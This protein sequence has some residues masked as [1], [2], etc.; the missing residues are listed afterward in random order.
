MTRHTIKHELA[1]I[2]VFIAI[3][4]ITFVGDWLTGWQ[5]QYYGLQ[6]RTLRGLIGIAM[7][8]LLHGSF[9]HLLGNSISLII[10]LPLLAG[11]RAS[12]LKT[13]LI[14]VLL[15]GSLLWIF[16]TPALHI[17]ASGLIYGLI[18]FLL[19]AGYF[20]RRIMSA[21]IALVVLFFYGTTLVFGVLP[22]INPGISWDGHLMG[23]IAGGSLAFVQ[24]KQLERKRIADA[25]T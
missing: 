21:I 2:L 22:F 7:M 16:G 3:L 9:G 8:P 5:L 17:G 14:I 23:A 12:T 11:S 25:S 18:C 10:L 15:S 13:S 4:W 1:G 19:G 6:P 24:A 20:E